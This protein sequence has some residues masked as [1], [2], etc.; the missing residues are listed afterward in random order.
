MSVIKVNKDQLN[1]ATTEIMSKVTDIN[2]TVTDLKSTLNSIPSHN[3]FSSLISKANLIAN[4]LDGIYTDLGNVTTNMNTYVNSIT[5]IDNE[6]LDGTTETV[7]QTTTTD[8][9]DSN[10]VNL[11]STVNNTGKVNSWSTAGTASLLSTGT[12]SYSS[13]SSGSSSGSSGNYTYSYS[14]SPSG[15]II[16]TNNF[17]SNK[18]DDDDYNV[19]AGGNYNYEGIEKYLE[20]VEGV[21]VTLP[22]GLG[23]VHTY[24]GWQCITSVSSKQYKLREAA[25][26]NFDEEGFAKIGD[27]YVVATTTTF[28]NIGDYIDVYQEDGTVIKCIIGDHKSQRD[29]DANQWGHNNGECVLEF[30][31]DKSTWYG[32]SMH[33]NPGTSSCHPEWNQNITKIVNKGNYF[34]LIDTDAAKFDSEDNSSSED[35]PTLITV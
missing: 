28:G 23:S 5:E 25:G 7:G 15:T 16:H 35:T 33:S 9:A 8:V 4:A 29:A 34:E 22:E 14:T 2:G 30:V 12:S 20:D 27:R 6:N 31:V 13:Y 21:T 19:A 18:L 10:V 26:M 1:T 17:S 3:D 32:T 24:M 11:S